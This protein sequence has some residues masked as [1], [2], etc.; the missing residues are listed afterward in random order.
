[1][2]TFFFKLFST[3]DFS[4]LPL[5]QWIFPSIGRELSALC[6]VGCVEAKREKIYLKCVRKMDFF[7]SSCFQ[8]IRL[9]GRP[10]I[11]S[12]VAVRTERKIMTGIEFHRQFN[13]RTTG[14]SEVFAFDKNAELIAVELNLTTNARSGGD[15]GDMARKTFILFR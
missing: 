9:F 5:F 4:S 10:F 8:L 13:Y 14:G 12:A 15:D 1:M 3:V 6:A 7:S 11:S 2:G